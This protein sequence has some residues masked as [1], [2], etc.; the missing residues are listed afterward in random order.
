MSRQTEVNS[1]IIWVR[2]DAPLQHPFPNVCASVFLRHRKRNSNFQFRFCAQMSNIHEFSRQS[3]V[4]RWRSLTHSIL[5]D[6]FIKPGLK[7]FLL[8]AL[9]SIIF[10][11]GCRIHNCSLTR[12]GLERRNLCPI[13][14]EPGFQHLEECSRPFWFHVN[15]FRKHVF[16]LSA[17]A[18]TQM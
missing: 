11:Q 13:N 1:K 10:V 9:L 12:G 5:I 14:R 16:F 18:H 6:L 8:P 15:F 2:S 4:G 7:N 17:F 3:D